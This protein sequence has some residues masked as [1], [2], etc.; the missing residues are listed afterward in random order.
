MGRDHDNENTAPDCPWP[1]ERDE[2]A[3]QESYRFPS[4]FWLVDEA[5]ARKS[6]IAPSFHLVDDLYSASSLSLRRKHQVF[7]LQCSD[8]AVPE[9]SDHRALLTI[10]HVH[11]WAQ[12]SELSSSLVYGRR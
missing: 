2:P 5:G 1:F 7:S 4:V 8:A 9:C 3:D 6:P 12:L 10:R 11:R